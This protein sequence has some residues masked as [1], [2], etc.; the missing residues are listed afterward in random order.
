MTILVRDFI[1]Q[2]SGF[3]LIQRRNFEEHYGV[4][5]ERIT[6][7]AGITGDYII[8]QTSEATRV[9]EEKVGYSLL[10]RKV[11]FKNDKTSV[12]YKSFFVEFETTSNN[13][14][15]KQESGHVK[16]INQ[17]C[18]LCINSGRDMFI[19][20][21]A[22]FN[23]ILPYCTHIRQTK[24]R[25]NGNHPDS[26]MKGKIIPLWAARINAIEIYRMP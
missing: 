1:R 6:Q 21:E 13:W 2:E 5:M 15:T 19:F 18:L 26:R 20:N 4:R 24:F 14:G 11:E 17:G 12:Q 25:S 9:L 3:E 16:A 7:T 8:V 23:R 22:A 10:N